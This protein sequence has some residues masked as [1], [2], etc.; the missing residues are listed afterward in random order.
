MDLT[1][2]GTYSDFLQQSGNVTLPQYL[3]E[4][5]PVLGISPEELG[6]LVLALARPEHE[7]TPWMRWA[8]DKGWATWQGTDANRR[9]VFTALWEKLYQQWV[10]EQEKNISKSQA[11]STDKNF[12]YCRIMK[13]L[14]KMRG[15]LSITSREQQLI[16]EFNLKYGWSTEFILSFFRL[17]FQRGLTQIR[18]YRPLAVQINRAG[19]YTLDGLVRFM[20][21]VDWISHKVAEIKKDYLGLYGMVTVME[22]DLYVKWSVNWQLTHSLIVRAAQETVGAKN[23]SF[24]YIDKVLEDWH[25]KGITTIE[26]AE[27]ALQERARQQKALRTQAEAKEV[28]P[29][30]ADNQS[31]SSRRMVKRGNKN[32]EGVE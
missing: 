17:C 16:Q 1:K 26:A 25:E 32:W 10:A 11:V 22:R 28:Y 24:K 19:I 31:K 5:L 18:A 2:V 27:Q 21:E 15:N 9:I 13:E 30:P 4:Q 8:L 20:D 12:D 23:A 29:K 14:D 6:Y 7:A 3:L